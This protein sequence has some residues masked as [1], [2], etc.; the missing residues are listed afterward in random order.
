MANRKFKRIAIATI[1]FLTLLIVAIPF[2]LHF[3]TN[4]LKSQVQQALGADSTVAAIDVGWSSIALRDVSIRAPVGWPAGETLRAA[5]VLVT[6]NLRSLVS[7]NI[8]VSK[9]TID[10]PYL[11]LLR[12]RDGHLRLLPSLLETPSKA[13]PDAQ[14]AKPIPAISIDS[15]EVNNG[16][17][18]FFDASIAQT[19]HKIRLEQLQAMVGNV[20]VPNISAHTALKLDGNIKGIRRDGTVNIDGWIDVV[21]KNSAVSTKLH[22]V[23][24]VSLEPYLI[25]ASETGVKHGAMDLD[26]K[27]TVR[28]NRLNAAGTVTLSGLE[29]EPGKGA[30]GTFMGVPR[31]AVIASLKNRSGQIVVPFT[32]QGNLS[33]PH[34]SLNENLA[35]R[36]G[37]GVASSLGISIAGLAHGVGNAA[38]G[39]EGA[40][41]KLLGK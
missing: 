35:T 32:L 38:Q 10:D 40:F 3:A 33:D 26:L 18:E 31:S 14:P 25:K 27:S 12:T 39:V 28:E 6:P 7:S 19:P 5:R 34:F 17:V 36:I 22:G 41:K 37:S 15:I 8:V 23:D 21:G 20:H 11:S 4:A 29:L 9:I 16:T 2:A 24:L 1:I 13:G 30:L